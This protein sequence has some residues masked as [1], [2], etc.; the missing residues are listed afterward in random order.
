MVAYGSEKYVPD[1][2]HWQC[3]KEKSWR[4]GDVLARTC[5]EVPPGS[6]RAALI[7]P[8]PTLIA[9]FPSLSASW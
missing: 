6:I 3:A 1:R 8:L 7:P 4:R 9:R 5:D 2:T